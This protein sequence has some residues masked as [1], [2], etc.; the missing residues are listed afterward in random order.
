MRGVP[1]PD[2]Q[3]ACK[4]AG[5]S[6]QVDVQPSCHARAWAEHRARNRGSA[7][8]IS[9]ASSMCMGTWADVR[10]MPQRSFRFGRGRMS[11]ILP[12]RGRQS[13]MHLNVYQDPRTAITCHVCSARIRLTRMYTSLTFFA[14]EDLARTV[15]V[16]SKTTVLRGAITRCRWRSRRNRPVGLQHQ[17]SMLNSGTQV[18]TEERTLTFTR[19]VFDPA[20]G[21][22]SLFS[23]LPCLTAAASSRIGRRWLRSAY[24][25]Q[26]TPHASHSTGV[27]KPFG[28]FHQCFVSRVR[29]APHDACALVGIRTI[30]PSESESSAAGTMCVDRGGV[31]EVPSKR[32]LRFSSPSFV[33]CFVI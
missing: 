32:R 17:S 9:D 24:L 5:T 14:L 1:N 19:L 15:L 21:V 12:N 26:E 30:E 23:V 16:T 25:R 20:S 6:Q 3:L 4:H 18:L 28:A 10:A 2:P 8:W 31:F 7:K 22:P 29:H 13:H 11:M 33:L 27:A